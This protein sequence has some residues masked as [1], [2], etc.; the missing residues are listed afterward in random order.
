M[1]G[2]EE[3]DDPGAFTQ[4]TNPIRPINLTHVKCIYDIEFYSS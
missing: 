1:F 2:L 3:L 4:N